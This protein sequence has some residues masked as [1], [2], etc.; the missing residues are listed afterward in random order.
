MS[1]KFISI[2]VING[3]VKYVDEWDM[4]EEKKRHPMEAYFGR[5]LEEGRNYGVFYHYD[6]EEK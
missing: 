5:P 6:D 1:K 3:R 2:T 4:D